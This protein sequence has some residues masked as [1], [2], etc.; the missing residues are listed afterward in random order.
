MWLVVAAIVLATSYPLSSYP[1][2]WLSEAGHL[3][4]DT[5]R[6]YVPLVQLWEATIPDSWPMPYPIRVTYE[7]MNVGIEC[8]IYRQTK[9]L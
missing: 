9:S 4:L 3:P 6:V 1:A 7:C 2:I 8:E 5:Y